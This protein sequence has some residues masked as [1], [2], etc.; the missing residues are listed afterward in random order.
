VANT[1]ALTHQPQFLPGKRIVELNGAPR[2]Q[3]RWNT[4]GTNVKEG[5]VYTGPIRLPGN[6]EVTVC[7]CAIDQEVYVEKEFKIPGKPED[8]VIDKTRKSTLKHE[9]SI[10]GIGDVYKTIKAA[11]DNNAKLIKAKLT[12]GDRG[13]R[14][15]QDAGPEE[16]ILDVSLGLH[17]RRTAGRGCSGRAPCWRCALT[18]HAHPTAAVL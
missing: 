3:I 2:G 16:I 9:I 13:L 15:L 10:G 6:K 14:P 11:E 18:A 8:Q 17:G 4:D 7:A 1:L 12:V 5:K